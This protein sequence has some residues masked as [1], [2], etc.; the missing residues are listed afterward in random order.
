MRTAPFLLVLVAACAA[1]GVPAGPADGWH[2][3]SYD[4]VVRAWGAPARST[5]LTDGADVHT[6]VSAAPAPRS[7]VTQSVG[8]GVRS[9]GG[10]TSIGIGT[11]VRF[12]GGTRSSA[13]AQCE[14]TLIFREG[15]VSEQ[16]WQGPA[17][18]CEAFRR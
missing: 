4:D 11:G 15:R 1:P 18:A 14:R 8:V 5:K 6:W 17:E 16:Q 12:A 7:G 9:G 2:G 3:A 13:P 10:G